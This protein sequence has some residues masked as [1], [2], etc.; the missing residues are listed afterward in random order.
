MHAILVRKIVG[1]ITRSS[2]IIAESPVHLHLSFTGNRSK[3]T[4]RSWLKNAIYPVEDFFKIKCRQFIFM[5]LKKKCVRLVIFQWTVTNLAADTAPTPNTP[6]ISSSYLLH[7]STGIDKTW[8]NKMLNSALCSMTTQRSHLVRW[9][10]RWVDQYDMLS[11]KYVKSLL[12]QRCVVEYYCPRWHD[13]IMSVKSWMERRALWRRRV[14]P[15]YEGRKDPI[16]GGTHL[17]VQPAEVIILDFYG[18]AEENS[19]RHVERN[20]LCHLTR[21]EAKIKM[22]GA[23]CAKEGYVCYPP[24]DHHVSPKDNF[25]C[26]HFF[27]ST[28]HLFPRWVHCCRL[29]P[30]KILLILLSD[31]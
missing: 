24:A 22:V 14:E 1:Q 20:S 31:C 19:L 7:S 13:L 4:S 23:M 8:S 26:S 16:I 5:T 2:K 21:T 18:A 11:E 12:P 17:T 25:V 29:F 10:T 6:P 28:D 15:V 9:C 27:S 3:P 30:P